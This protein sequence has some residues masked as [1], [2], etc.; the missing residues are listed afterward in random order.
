MSKSLYSCY[1]GMREPLVQTQVL[2]Y[3]RELVKGGHELHLLT[4]EPE[5]R[6]SWT[7]DEL[8]S[9]Q[10]ELAE[11]GISWHYM[12]YHKRPSVPATLYDIAAGALRVRQLTRQHDLD[13][14]HCR[15]HHPMMMAALAR[16]ML[17][18]KRSARRPKLLFDI[19]GFFPEEYVDA[20][21]WKSGGLIFRGVKR[22][23]KWLMKQA[24]AFVV[25]TE[26]ARDILFPESRAAGRDK[27]G[28]PVE[29]IPCCVDL[30]RFRT[31]TPERGRQMREK[32]G[33]GERFVIA[34][35]GAFGGWYMTDEMVAFLA[36]AKAARPDTFALILTQ[37]DRDAV[38]AKLRSNGFADKDML[39]KKVPASEIPDHLSAADAALSF[40]KP[41]YSKL[42]SS[43]TKNAEYLA[44]GVPII[45]NSGVG[46]VDELIT[47]SGAGILLSDLSPQSYH[48]ALIRL[49]ELGDI[50]ERCRETARREFD[51][52]TVGGPAYRRLYAA[53]YEDK[54]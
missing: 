2:P 28:R 6:T 32:L 52:T 49:R 10:R 46:D 3:L 47:S 35:V 19:R 11:Q 50:S 42:S 12:A 17:G 37:S 18:G 44:C 25:L 34:Y 43:P 21:V 1:F 54:R 8:S 5:L 41:C 30:E 33:V 29:V 48:D 22:A 26:K 39:V 9:R 53:M 23:E 51:L 16:K 4:F 38:T 14:L 24:D 13:I 40:I 15:V 7:T 36:E 27:H 45:A 31:A 20:G